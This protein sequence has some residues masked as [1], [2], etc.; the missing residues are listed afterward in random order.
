AADMERALRG[1]GNGAGEVSEEF[2]KLIDTT[3]RRLD[4]LQ[5]EISLVGKAGLEADALRFKYDLLAQAKEKNIKLGPEEHA[6]I[7]ELTEAYR[8]LSKELATLQALDDIMFERSL[9]GLSD[10]D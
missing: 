2:T 10:G 7:D 4:Q 1:A 9:I 8:R 5:Q 6:K 3:Q